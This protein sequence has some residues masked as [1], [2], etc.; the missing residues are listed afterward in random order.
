MRQR[1]RNDI[2]ALAV[3]RTSRIVGLQ[4][5]IASGALV[6]AAIGV[7]FFFVLDQLRPAE[8]LERPKPGEHKIYID[9]TEAM[10]AFVVVGVLAVAVSGTLSLVITRRAVGPLGRALS[11]Q[12]TFVQ[13]ASH[14]LRTPLAVLDARLQV[15]QRSLPEGDPSSGLVSELRADARTL[16]DVVNDLL[17]AA[18]EP[19]AGTGGQPAPVVAAVER[20][21]E[22]MQV[23]ASERG[24]SIV[25]EADGSP[26][27]L[28]PS[29]SI[30]RCI[31]ALLDNAVTHAPEGSTVRVRIRTERHHVILGVAD[32]GPGVV[33]ID[34][35]RIFDRFARAQRP[36]TT[37]STRLSFGIGLALVREVAARYGGT[38]RVAETSAR[39]TVLELVLPEAPSN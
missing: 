36:A 29:T 18:D 38:V 32:S 14:E 27:T 15:L 8:L 30:Q 26:A 19:T 11:I 31:T 13:D 20:S 23:L 22:A 12:R 5:T 33:G 6:F 24:I 16:I 4:I 34:P 1:P 10:I 28:V 37:T 7:A 39:G 17:L 3:R 21:V 9:S 35:E 2:D 25:L